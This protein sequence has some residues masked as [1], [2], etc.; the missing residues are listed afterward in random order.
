MRSLVASRQRPGGLRFCATTA[1]T[2]TTRPAP[3]PRARRRDRL[4]GDRTGTAGAATR[5]DHAELAGR[6]RLSRPPAGPESYPDE[7]E[8]VGASTV[9]NDTQALGRPTGGS[10]TR[11]RSRCVSLIKLGRVGRVFAANSVLLVGPAHPARRRPAARSLLGA[12]VVGRRAPLTAALAV[13]IGT[14]LV[15]GGAHRA[16]AGLPAHGLFAF[17]VAWGR[18]SGIAAIAATPPATSAPPGRS[19][20]RGARRRLRGAGR[21]RRRRAGRSG[22]ADLALAGRLGPNLSRR[23]PGIGGGCSS[24]ASRAIAIAV[25]YRL[26]ARRDLGAGLLPA[27]ASARPPPALRG[28]LA[29]AWRLQRGSLVGLAASSSCSRSR[30]Q[31]RDQRRRAVADQ[32]AAD[33]MA[34]SAASRGLTDAYLAATFGFMI[35]ASAYGV[36]FRAAG[37][38]PTRPPDG[39]SRCWPAVSAGPAGCTVHVLV[40]LV[41]TTAMLSPASARSYACGCTTPRSSDGSWVPRRSNCRGGL[42]ADRDRGGWFGCSP[43]WPGWAG[44]SWPGSWCSAWSDRC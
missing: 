25:A 44:P 8:R 1:S 43:G 26:V 32:Q 18:C 10:T 4:R 30:R 33:F 11:P 2:P 38:A 29:L 3:P 20:A 40:A 36:Q 9:F 37:R 17:G 7:A 12:T 23:T 27:S 19:R 28:P 21:R 35:A 42:G 24:S 13:A 31:H 22:L 34:S 6:L 15:L 5:S 41:G 14:N 16:A 39:L